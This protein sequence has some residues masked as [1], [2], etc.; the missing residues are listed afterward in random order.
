MQEEGG[1]KVG[2]M[3]LAELELLE[4][5]LVLLPLPPVDLLQEAVGCYQDL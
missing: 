1:L 3:L 2:V 5:H 4:V